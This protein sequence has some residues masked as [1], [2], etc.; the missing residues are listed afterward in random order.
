[1]IKKILM[2]FAIFLWA[3]PLGAAPG[4]LLGGVEEL[5]LDNGMRFLLLRR[6]GAP[7]FS[8]YIRVKVG[9]VDEVDGKTGIAHLL[10]H[11]AFKGTDQ[12]GTKDYGKEK[13]LLGQV[14][15]IH[16]KKLQARGSQKKAL[17]EQMQQLIQEAG[18]WVV[19]EEFSEIYQRNGATGL[20]ATT[21]QDLT[22]YF[23]SLPSTKLKLW[24][25]LESSR[26]KNPVFREFYSERNVVG[27]ERRMRVEDSPFGKLYETFIQLAFVKSP[28]RRPTIGYKLDIEKLSATDLRKFYEKYYVPSNMV[29][30]IVGDIDI[31]ET[32]Q[33]LRQYFN[34]LPAKPPAT[35]PNVREPEPTRSKRKT[36]RFDASPSLIF[37]YLKPNLPHPDDYVFDIFEQ[38]LCEGR[39]SRLYKSL[40]FKE[41][42]VQRIDCSAS[43]PGS[44]LENLFFVYASVRQ[45]H[46]P[47]QVLRAFDREIKRIADQG[48]SE[49]ELKKA[50]KNLMSQ[51]FF[52]LQSNNDIA[53]ALSY[54]E[55]VSGN[56]KYILDHQKKIQEVTSE[57]IQRVIKTYL[58]PSRR[59][60]AILKPLKGKG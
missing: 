17:T 49:T 14:E 59:R 19:K 12:I 30:A 43:T 54:F 39:T 33:I 31:E 8:A 50:K 1:M 46:T 21:S 20:N 57:E 53:R 29:G 37:G 36:I 9:G 34:S 35:E 15:E 10:E 23:V 24:A 45:G 16:A 47:E 4:T 44:R 38:V 56:W 18:E 13:A 52:D 27:E 42:L 28:Y 5:T 58:K 22:S 60:I 25:F 32:K 48:V 41:K 26:L 6:Q 55:A 3:G 2:L 40:V 51:W 7:V 11:M